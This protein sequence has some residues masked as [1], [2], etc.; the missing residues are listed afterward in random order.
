MIA[1]TMEN[2]KPQQSTTETALTKENFFED[3]CS[4]LGLENGLKLDREQLETAEGVVVPVDDMSFEFKIVGFDDPIYCTK[5][6][7]SICGVEEDQISLKQLFEDKTSVMTYSLL[8]MVKY[9][10]ER[11]ERIEERLDEL[12]KAV[13]NAENPQKKQQAEENLERVK[14]Q[15]EVYKQ[16][17]DKREEKH[18]E[19]QSKD[20][21][22][23][24]K[25]ELCAELMRQAKTKYKFE[26][27]KAIRIPKG[28]QV[29]SMFID[30]F[31][32]PNVLEREPDF[33][34]EDWEEPEVALEIWLKIKGEY[35]ETRDRWGDHAKEVWRE[36]L[37]DAFV[38]VENENEEEDEIDASEY[39][40]R[41]LAKKDTVNENEKPRDIE[42][43]SN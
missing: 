6:I 28:R 1:S 32:L 33:S 23:I 8:K 19:S 37:K 5:I 35:A 36:S 16:L 30:H 40:K 43:N 3:A 25:T 29:V 26:E 17:K 42:R 15:V 39:V 31:F 27:G 18:R 34:D 10:E 12:E 7:D 38:S 2:N 11:K 14:A 13:K 24:N 21:V 9:T 41:E 20:S 22:G 4:F